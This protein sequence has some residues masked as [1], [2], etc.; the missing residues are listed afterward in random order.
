MLLR[1]LG[2]WLLF[3]TLARK[4]EILADGVV[5]S[6]VG[7]DLREDYCSDSGSKESQNVTQVKAILAGQ[8]LTGTTSVAEAL[9]LMGYRSYHGEDVMT[10]CPELMRDVPDPEWFARP[11]SRCGIEAISIQ[12][13][14]DMLPVVLQVSPEAKVILTWRP[15]PEWIVSK[16]TRDG[17][18]KDFI[19]HI[20]SNMIV[21]PFRIWRA[22]PI[23]DAVTGLRGGVF[24][25][26]YRKGTPLGGAD[27][28]T[29]VGLLLWMS[30]GR[31]EYLDE[32]VNL[33]FRGE[34]KISYDEEAYLTQQDEIRRLA[35]GRLLEF[36]IKRHGWAT[37]TAFL[38]RPSPP[39]KP[40]LPHTRSKNSWMNDPLLENSREVAAV[41]ICF[42][43]SWHVLSAFLVRAFVLFVI[44]LLRSTAI[45]ACASFGTRQHLD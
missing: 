36:D 12:P 22:G 38:G 40:G 1:W 2:W 14:V 29:V 15:Y 37:L 43:L 20:V 10:L 13:F 7:C 9:R 32:A 31:F 23:I 45:S 5:C 8:G 35:S 4:I 24:R 26:A 17:T 41:V 19:A 44:R 39:G 18:G 42:L 16:H 21:G 25:Q 30:Q 34:Y 3:L 33:N 27:G 6:L 11:L 28:I